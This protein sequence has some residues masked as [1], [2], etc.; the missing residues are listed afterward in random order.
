[1]LP[2]MFLLMLQQLWPGLLTLSGVSLLM[3]PDVGSAEGSACHI[4]SATL[5]LLLSSYCIL[6]ILLQL[7]LPS[8]AALTCLLSLLRFVPTKLP[9]CS[10]R[11]LQAG[12]QAR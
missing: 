2:G 3:L 12:S 6:G 4:D 9:R 8:L 7:L 10:L 5:L 1:M 11:F